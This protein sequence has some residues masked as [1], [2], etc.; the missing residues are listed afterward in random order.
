MPEQNGQIVIAERGYIFSFDKRLVNGYKDEAI[1]LKLK[2]DV[3][4]TGLT[5]RDG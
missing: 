1:G 5:D 3:D 4:F 2:M